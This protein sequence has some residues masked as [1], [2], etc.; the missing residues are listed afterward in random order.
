MMVGYM[1]K[2]WFAKLG[3]CAILVTT[4]LREGKRV[5][6]KM[7]KT[8][9]RVLAGLLVFGLIITAVLP[10]ILGGY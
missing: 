9:V 2:Q 7:R 8:V 5:S 1:A 4:M 3:I 10:A 6:P